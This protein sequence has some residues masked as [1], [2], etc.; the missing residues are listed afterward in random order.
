[1]VRPKMVR[2]D[3]LRKQMSRQIHRYGRKTLRGV[4]QEKVV[5]SCFFKVYEQN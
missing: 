4:N 1:M 3:E 2:L 5:Y